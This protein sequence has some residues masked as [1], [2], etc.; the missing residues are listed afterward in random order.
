MAASA[1]AAAGFSAKPALLSALYRGTHRAFTLGSTPGRASWDYRVQTG[2]PS[3]APV[4]RAPRG[5]VLMPVGRC[6]KPPECGVT[7]PARG[8]RSRS[9]IG[10]HR[11]T[12]LP[13]RAGCYVTISVTNVNRSVTAIFRVPRTRCSV[14][15]CTADPGSLEFRRRCE[16]A[17]VPGLQ[18]TTP[19]RHSALRRA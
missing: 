7:K 5:P 15:R 18:R 1:D 11:L 4:Q 12:P 2:G 10:R 14:K 8:D 9:I 19:L 3:P 13:E 6:P 16:L 17:T